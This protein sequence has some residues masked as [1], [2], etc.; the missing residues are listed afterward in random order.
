MNQ[1]TLSRS[2][3]DA[4]AEARARSAPR[5]IAVAAPVEGEAPNWRVAALGFCVSL[6]ATV[7]LA[8]GL[9]AL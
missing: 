2:L 3:P 9:A 6:A 1:S 8:F 4:V 5:A 7:T